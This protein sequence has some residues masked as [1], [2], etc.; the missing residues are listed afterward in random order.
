MVLLWCGEQKI[1][2]LHKTKRGG[3]EG[4]GGGGVG[5]RGHLLLF[6]YYK[7]GTNFFIYYLFL[8]M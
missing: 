6:L 3:G 1:R 7:V 8:C 4:V 5:E 2:L